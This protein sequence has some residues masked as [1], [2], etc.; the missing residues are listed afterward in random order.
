MKTFYFLNLFLLCFKCFI[1]QNYHKSNQFIASQ[2]IKGVVNEFLLKQGILDY[3]VL[4]GCKSINQKWKIQEIIK[5][6]KFEKSLVKVKFIKDI[7][8][9]K[10]D[11]EK[12]TI[13]L[14]C[15]SQ[16]L[17]D[18]NE[19]TEIH[20]SV[21]K[22]IKLISFALEKINK[23]SL[24]RSKPHR[25]SHQHVIYYE[26][27]LNNTESSID[28]LTM[29]FFSEANCKLQLTKINSFDKKS[30]KWTKT[31]ENYEKFRNFH[32]CLRAFYVEFGTEMHFPKQNIAKISSFSN[33]SKVIENLLQ[34][35]EEF[36]VFNGFIID[37]MAQKGNFTPFY[38]IRTMEF[39]EKGA[40]TVYVPNRGVILPPDEVLTL[41]SYDGLGARL[42]HITNVAIDV[43]YA[44]V[45]TPGEPYSPYE[46]LL[47]PF[48]VKTWILLTC[49]FL[50][51]FVVIF[52]VNRMSKVVQNI[53]F[54]VGNN[55][56]AINIIG[57]FFG[58]AQTVVPKNYFARVILVNFV[59]F[60]MIFRSGYQ[61]NFVII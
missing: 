40:R 48:D 34:K 1:S 21:S 31:L 37:I 60:C 18:F 30:R 26:F 45:V 54:G 10:S 20:L 44:I 5:L 32:G 11:I 23:F 22:S 25:S 15:S 7:K 46:K 61:G 59:F 6:I 50:I 2:A 12:S 28:L 52:A 16:E 49:T 53:F 38:Q 8:K 35:G 17:N 33:Q 3:E 14:F 55:S 39:S 57:T 43:E 13:A 19:A 47:L 42:V 41:Y 56:A 4:V 36:K 58:I 9:F 24:K 51:G 29:D 27:V